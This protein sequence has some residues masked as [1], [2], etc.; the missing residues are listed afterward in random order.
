MLPLFYKPDKE[1]YKYLDKVSYE[2][3]Y[4]NQNFIL[5]MLHPYTP[6]RGML[7]TFQLGNGKTYVSAALSHLYNKHGLG[8]IFLAH[9]VSTIENFKKEY[10]VF[11]EEN[12]VENS[13]QDI[14][15][16]GITKFLSS[17]INIKNKLIIIDEAHN[18]R[19]NASRYKRLQSI[20]DSDDTIKILII[21]AT[22][23][24]DKI[25]EIYSLR[26]LIEKDAPVAYSESIYS[27]VKK[28]YVG[29][30]FIIGTLYKSIMKGVQLQKYRELIH[31]SY[32]DIYTK[33]RQASLTAGPYSPHIPLDEQSSKI[34]A[35]LDSIVFGELAVAFSFFVKRGLHFIRD[36]LNDRGWKEWS[37]SDHDDA[38]RYAILDGKTTIEHTYNIMN[39]FNS[40][41]NIDGSIIQLLIGSS[42][43]NESISLRN[44]KHVHILTPF[45]NYGQIRQAIGRTIRMRSH[46]DFTEDVTVNIYLHVSVIEEKSSEN[47]VTYS[48]IDLDMYETAY[49][50][51]LSINNQLEFMV[52]ESIW[53]EEMQDQPFSTSVIPAPDNRFIYLISE[54]VWDFRQCFD[55]NISKISWY[56][57]YRDKA[58][59]YFK[60]GTSKIREI[61]QTV[62]I[63]QPESGKV[64]AWRSIIDDRIRITDL[65][66]STNRKKMKRGKLIN[67]MNENEIV[68][69]AKSLGVAST[70][71]DILTELH[72]RGDYIDKQI[73]IK[74]DL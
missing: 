15:Y 38:P 4:P 23:M 33:I 14:R 43:M 3:T 46:S 42:V 17:N 45:W 8:V 36:A 5:S 6:Y 44:V 52:K 65:R 30:D 7:L 49:T 71:K 69:I 48:G 72:R 21:T 35:L 60:D 39:Q 73:I 54:W 59:C 9:N 74:N 19:E 11:V 62:N 32:K 61:P 50:K 55:T 12:Q 67:N 10:S 26:N 53:S 2:Q 25:N 70:V 1:V 40:L 34:S 51:N 24:I 56:N 28:R 57:I 29:D 37:E 64:T 68:S 47:E 58:I 22:P 16:M 18:I 13:C 27:N 63:P 66:F 31:N 20:L 41:L